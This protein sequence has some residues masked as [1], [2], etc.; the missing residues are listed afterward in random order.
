MVAFAKDDTA[1]TSSAPSGSLGFALLFALWM[2]ATSAIAAQAIVQRPLRL[3]VPFPPGGGLDLTARLLSPLLADTLAKPIV[4]DNRGGGG[5]LIGLEIAS[6]ASAEGH[7]F[8][9]CSASHVIQAIAM[10]PAFDLFRDLVPVSE[11]IA[12]PYALVVHNGFPAKTVAELI[13]QAKA[14]PGGINYAS[15]G[16]ASLQHV[17][18]E[19]FAQAAGFKALHV[20]YKGVGPVLPDLFAGRIHFFMASLSAL[21]PHI[22]ARAV[23][24]LAVTSAQ[25]SAVLPH[26]PT[27]IEAGVP[28]YVVVQWQAVLA[29]AGTTAAEVER[30]QQAIAA[31]L[32]SPEIVRSIT[33]DGSTIVG[34]TPSVFR[35]ALDA[36][37]I[38][39]TRVIEQ[40]G[41]RGL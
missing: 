25:R 37:R 34:S 6:R 41:L 33:A 5:G 14:K 32:R 24:A 11:V 17:A 12:S 40:A 18:T 26:L 28:G 7:V 2:L 19:M 30:F 3:I 27:L 10:K 36:E 1:A 15:A 22:R 23:T 4:V 29:P 9:M 8:V 16:N 21:S 35:K 20:P 13:E 38:K 39:W 31:A